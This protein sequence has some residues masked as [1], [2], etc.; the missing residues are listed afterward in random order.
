MMSP[1]GPSRGSLPALVMRTGLIAPGVK[2][3]QARADL[4]LQ[5]V[6]DVT[7]PAEYLPAALAPRLERRI[8]LFFLGQAWEKKGDVERAKGF[9]KKIISMESDEDAAPRLKAKRSLRVLEEAA[10]G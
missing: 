10:H 9:Y 8:F 6:M 4:D 5:H 3:S 7:N 1:N 2:P